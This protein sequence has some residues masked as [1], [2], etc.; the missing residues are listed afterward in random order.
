MSK[1]NTPSDLPD[2]VTEHVKLYLEKPDQ[3]HLWDSRPIGGPGILPCLLLI[4]RGRKTGNVSMLPLIYGE[5]DGSFV[6]VASKGGSPAHP[7]WYLN[8]QAESDCEIRVGRN[9]HRVRA[10]TT[11]GDER[12]KLWK[13]MAEIYPPYIDYQAATERKIPVLVLDP[14]Q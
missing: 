13:M 9:H 8:L 11:E 14:G 3:A 4:T 6:I 10:R 5:Y 2:W 12:E 1:T 7:A